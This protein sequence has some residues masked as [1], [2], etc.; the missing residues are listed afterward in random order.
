MKAIAKQVSA[1]SCSF[2]E[3]EQLQAH[4]LATNAFPSQWTWTA[5][6]EFVSPNASFLLFCASAGC[7]GHNEK[8]IER[9]HYLSQ[10]MGT[11]VQIKGAGCQASQCLNK[12][13]AGHSTCICSTSCRRLR[14]GDHEFKC[15]SASNTSKKWS[16]Y[17]KLVFL[18]SK[19][20]WIRQFHMAYPDEIFIVFY[21]A[22][23]S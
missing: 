4:T 8:G 22:M 18:C 11:T 10:K 9:G 7:Y 14:Q 15:N 12:F 23:V 6:C 5:R 17:M 21:M 19:D 1:A 16:N 20:D 2:P 13:K 3:C